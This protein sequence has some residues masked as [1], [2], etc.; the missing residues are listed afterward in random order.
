MTVCLGVS[1]EPSYERCRFRDRAPPRAVCV[2]GPYAVPDEYLWPTTLSL[3][4]CR[5]WPRPT[6]TSTT[7]DDL[8][9]STGSWRPKSRPRRTLDKSYQ[10][11]RVAQSLEARRIFDLVVLKL[12]PQVFDSLRMSASSSRWSQDVGRPGAEPALTLPPRSFSYPLLR[13]TQLSLLIKKNVLHEGWQEGDERDSS[14][15]GWLDKVRRR[16]VRRTKS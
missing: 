2:I 15:P 11:L 10:S 5:I 8:D 3:A 16:M 14:L 13:D 7:L 1:P 12:T 4:C 9:S 6:M